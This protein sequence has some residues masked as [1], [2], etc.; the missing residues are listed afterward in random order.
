MSCDI[1]ASS[2][3]EP[4]SP[5]AALR[6]RVRSNEG[7]RGPWQ[8]RHPGSALIV[9]CGL[10]LALLWPVGALTVEAP[11]VTQESPPA[12]TAPEDSTKKKEEL[13]AVPK[14]LLAKRSALP[15]ALVK[16]T[17]LSLRDLKAMEQHFKKLV[18]RVSPAV[19]AVRVGYGTGSGVV[20]SEDGLVLTAAHVCDEPNRNVFFTFP[21]GKTAH[22]KTLGTNHE[23]DAGLMKITDQ[24]KWPHVEIGSL[25][26]A[27]VGDWVLA[28]GHPGGF[29][30]ERPM[31]VR[32][33]RI[34]RLASGV[35]QSDCT[36][37]GGDSG[38]PLF[39]MHG[40]VI[41]IHSRIS[42]STAA[43]FHVSIGAYS[44]SWQ[45]L[46]KSESWGGRTRPTRPYVG[47][48]GADHP[49]GCQLGRVDDNSP[50][51]KAGLRT[52]DIIVKV[53]G[54][55]VYDYAA[56]TGHVERSKPGDEMTL[57]IKRDD[58]EMSL[59]MTVEAARRR[60]R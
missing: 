47:V 19:V 60:P 34:I 20:I 42:D 6:L 8:Q 11:T 54:E 29:D 48:R 59:S 13:P 40:R 17:P 44:D 5:E 31:V 2:F 53:N 22:G 15:G 12:Q 16:P 14:P 43:N 35:L 37:V 10:F 23:L 25:D 30:R 52:G 56:F 7:T 55:E 45:R 24:G 41:G 4:V 27:R 39:D 38:G 50:A 58:K 51:S 18:G 49:D 36:L 21:D 28:L 26:G 9:G 1:T 3:D 57:L 46:A 32:L 33:G